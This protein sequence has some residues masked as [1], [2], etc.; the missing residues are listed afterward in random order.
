VILMILN[1]RFDSDLPAVL[2]G[3][4]KGKVVPAK[5]AE[6]RDVMRYL[7]NLKEC[8]SKYFRAIGS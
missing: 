8:E 4:H 6:T 3:P 1:I 5:R 7:L 2:N